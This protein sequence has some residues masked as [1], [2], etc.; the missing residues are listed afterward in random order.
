MTTLHIR[1]DAPQDGHYPIRLTLK[2]PGP[3]DLEAEAKIQFA[4]T[5]QEQEDLRRYMEDYLQ[6]PGSFTHV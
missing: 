3:P 4:L 6:R 5:P 1:Q 2:H